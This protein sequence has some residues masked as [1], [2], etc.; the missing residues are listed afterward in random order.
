[1]LFSM[2]HVALSSRDMMEFTALELAALQAIFSETPEL[3]EALDRQLQGANVTRR[4]N[5]GGGFFTDISVAD[6]ILAVVS[7]RVLGNNVYADV[8]GLQH[9]VGLILFMEGG[10]LALLEV[11]SQFEN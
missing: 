3:L 9:G 5:T 7:Q 4:Q 6:E 1:M 11:V 10:K 8:N 2:R